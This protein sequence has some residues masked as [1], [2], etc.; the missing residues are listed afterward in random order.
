[1]VKNDQNGFPKH[2]QFSNPLNRSFFF[3]TIFFN[4]PNP[5]TIS[6]NLNHL[7]HLEIC[8]VKPFSKLFFKLFSKP[9]SNY[10]EWSKMTK[11]VFSNTWIICKLTRNIKK[12]LKNIGWNSQIPRIYITIKINTQT[13]K[14]IEFLVNLWIT[15]T[16][17]SNKVNYHHLPLCK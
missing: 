10:L 8:K 17:F 6:L 7:Y 2:N 4:F 14:V 13:F 12:I 3:S 1:M 5:Y 9:F 15:C 11:M 16:C